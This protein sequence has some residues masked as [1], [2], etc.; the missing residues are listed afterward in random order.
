MDVGYDP[1]MDHLYDPQQKPDNQL[2]CGCCQRQIF[3]GEVFYEMYILSKEIPVCSD[4]FSD[5]EQS[6]ALMEE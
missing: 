4:C 6:A 1:N 3:M 2:R 5:M